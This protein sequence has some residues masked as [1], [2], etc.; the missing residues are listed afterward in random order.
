MGNENTRRETFA[1][2]LRKKSKEEI[3]RQKRA[4]M[5]VSPATTISQQDPLFGDP[6]MP[7]VNTLNS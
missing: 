6:K 1:V 2:L 5:M 4:K 7:F 3:F